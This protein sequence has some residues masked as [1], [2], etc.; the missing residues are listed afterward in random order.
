MH[1]LVLNLMGKPEPKVG[2]EG[3]FSVFHAVA[4]ATAMGR[5]GEQAF[6]R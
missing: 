2:L 3:K 1:P 5:A 4:V 6:H